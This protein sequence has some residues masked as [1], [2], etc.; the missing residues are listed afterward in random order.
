MPRIYGVNWDIPLG[1]PPPT[2][3]AEEK[4]PR[5]YAAPH[6]LEFSRH[7]LGGDQPPRRRPARLSDTIFTRNVVAIKAVSDA[8]VGLL[9]GWTSSQKPGH[10]N[11][12][13]RLVLSG[14]D[15]ATVEKAWR[16]AGR[17]SAEG[18]PLQQRA[19][20]YPHFASGQCLITAG[21]VAAA[22]VVAWELASS[23]LARVR[24]K[25]EPRER[26][27]RQGWR[28]P[29]AGPLLWPVSQLRSRRS[30]PRRA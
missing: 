15:L 4:R 13:L 5:R 18:V 19:C 10:S 1:I 7:L 14:S 20:H 11:H 25:A 29:Y 26:S 12:E 16:I 27:V 2:G 23:F 21:S 17:E 8:E 9:Q 6:G 28:A 30:C 22:L 3:R 24:P